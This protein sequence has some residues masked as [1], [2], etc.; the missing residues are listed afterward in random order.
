MIFF[1]SFFSIS[2]L[3]FH[4]RHSIRHFFS[5][6]SPTPTIS[7]VTL[8]PF[9]H[10]FIQSSFIYPFI[11]SFILSVFIH[12]FIHSFLIHSFIHSFIHFL[13]IYSFIHS[14]IHFLFIYSFIHSFIHPFIH[15]FIS[16]S[17][18]HSFLIHPPFLRH[19]CLSSTLPH[20]PPSYQCTYKSVQIS[21]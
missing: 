20:L 13:F 6:I 21:F 2:S 9:I 16:H 1:Q 3:S 10:S 8:H 11:H 18:I 12:S 17:S 15:S 14:F 4:R 5:S 7:H 19:F